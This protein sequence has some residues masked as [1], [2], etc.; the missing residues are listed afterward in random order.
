MSLTYDGT[1]IGNVPREIMA[2]YRKDNSVPLV[3]VTLADEA[4]AT[5]RGCPGIDPTDFIYFY[6]DFLGGAV[7]EHK[8][9]LIDQNGATEALVND[10]PGG[11]LALALTNDNEAQSAGIAWND[12][13]TIAPNS[14]FVFE[15]RVKV[16]V[17]ATGSVSIVIGMGSAYNATHDSVADHAWFRFVGS[18]A[19]L[20]ESDDAN[21]DTDDKATDVTVTAD[22]QYR[23][24]RIDGSTQ[25]AIKFYVDGVDKTPAFTFTL[26]NSAATDYLQPI[27]AIEKGAATTV[28]TLE[29]DWVRLMAR[30]F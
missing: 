3:G 28:G 16:K 13:V 18:G 24:L 25:S 11:V 2:R 4:H 14:K 1:N 8:W 9:T 27:I 19:L 7:D 26:A 22:D 23:I 6:D 29:I 5:V 21:T 30:K 15:A 20:C 17:L 10:E 12:K